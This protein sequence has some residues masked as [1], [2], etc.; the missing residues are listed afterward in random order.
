MAIFASPQSGGYT[1]RQ[2][3]GAAGWLSVAVVGLL[4]LAAVPATAQALPPGMHLLDTVNIGGGLYEWRYRF[5]PVLSLPAGAYFE[6][7]GLYDVQAS[8]FTSAQ[9][10]AITHTPTTFRMTWGGPASLAAGSQDCPTAGTYFYYRSSSGTGATVPWQRSD[11]PAEHGTVLGAGEPT[12]IPAA[13]SV[14]DNWIGFGALNPTQGTAAIPAKVIAAK[15]PAGDWPAT[16]TVPAVGANDVGYLEIVAP[17][18]LNLSV[19]MNGPLTRCGP[20][21]QAFAGVDTRKQ[22]PGPYQLATQ[23][24]VAFRGKFLTPAGAA[25]ASP[26]SDE[27]TAYDDWTGW[28]TGGNDPVADAGWLWPSATDAWTGEA[29]A[30]YA[31]VTG[32]DLQVERD[33]FPGSATGGPAAICFIERVLRRGQ[34]DVEGNYRQVVDITLTYA[35]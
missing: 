10:W 18:R 8:G 1:A 23:W 17:V 3:D 7:T 19:R 15:S 24:K 13:V 4:L 29:V 11:V 27:V 30:G 16:A 35:E 2:R 33:Q 31:T 26:T 6:I 20:A 21:G 32:L 25:Y 5:V 34:Q 22:T 12:T 14:Y 9:N 28:S